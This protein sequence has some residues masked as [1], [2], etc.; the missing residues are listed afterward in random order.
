MYREPHRLKTGRKLA[1]M[2]EQL[3]GRDR[4]LFEALRPLILQPH[5]NW[6]A[7]TPKICGLAGRHPND[8]ELQSTCASAHRRKAPER[9]LHYGRRAV[10]LDPDYADAW[11]M[12][13]EANLSLG[14]VQEGLQDASRC[15]EVS[16]IAVDCLVVRGEVY[17]ARGQCDASAAD[18]RQ[19]N[20]IVQGEDGNNATHALALAALGRSDDAVRGALRQCWDSERDH[21][22]ELP[23]ARYEFW[24][25][26][27]DEAEERLRGV[28]SSS[29][30]ID[31]TRVRT[32]AMLTWVLAESGRARA[33]DEV[34]QRA[35]DG[36]PR[37]V[38][39]SSLYP[40]ASL[41]MRLVDSKRVEAQV[42]RG[43]LE[44]NTQRHGESVTFHLVHDE[45]SARA[46]LAD[47]ASREDL[48]RRFSLWWSEE[49]LELL[50][51][52]HRLVGVDAQ[53]AHFY[54]IV[55]R[56]CSTFRQP[57]HHVRASYWLGHYKEKE[58]KKDEA[59]AAYQTVLDRWGT[60]ASD[61]SS[62]GWLEPGKKRAKPKSITAEKARKR[63]AALGCK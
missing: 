60:P 10:A 41:W 28:L 56:H 43:A 32:Y 18:G 15:I 4:D 2:R 20:A 52:A 30:S 12:V 54:G 45:A 13:M 14:N 42:A 57:F 1:T 17:A 7:F 22:I 34:A 25:G 44:T 63:R 55:A 9:A 5:V 61:P 21:T 50:G 16:P 24:T 53:A 36:L 11:Q 19:I 3:V 6:P 33:A 58:G 40:Y 29:D 35:I 26:R 46:A 59:C 39:R 62:R 48:G 37:R 27:F 31:A 47:S 51:R 38:S 23:L 8:A 49:A